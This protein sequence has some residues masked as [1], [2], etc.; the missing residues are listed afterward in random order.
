MRKIRHFRSIRVAIWELRIY[1]LFNGSILKVKLC[2]MLLISTSII[3]ERVLACFSA[4]NLDNWRTRNWVE[5]P[6]S[7]LCHLLIVSDSRLLNLGVAIGIHTQVQLKFIRRFLAFAREGA[8][9]MLGQLQ[10]LLLRVAV[11]VLLVHALS[12]NHG[13]RHSRWVLL[14]LL[15]DYFWIWFARFKLALFNKAFALSRWCIWN[16]KL[17]CLLLI[18]TSSQD[19]FR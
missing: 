16:N 1:A 18:L 3:A 10:I 17:F 4:I 15:I 12:W 6:L 19:L 9:L 8:S 13:V 5:V 2:S 7:P 14:L 11:I